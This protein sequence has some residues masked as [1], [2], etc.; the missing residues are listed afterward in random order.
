[1][2]AREKASKHR[3]KSVN[4]TFV[5]SR[6]DSAAVEDKSSKYRQKNVNTMFESSSLDSTAIEEKLFGQA[7]EDEDSD[8]GPVV[9][10]CGKCKLPVGDSL[11]WDGSEDDQNQIRL[12]RE[13][14]FKLLAFHLIII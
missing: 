6:T 3:Q 1:M 10:I 12:K 5:A 14:I 11:S 8:D 13:C 7:E 4:T 9:F 2:A